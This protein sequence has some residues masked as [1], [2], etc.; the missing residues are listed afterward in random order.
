MRAGDPARS[1][2]RRRHAVRRRSTSG[3]AGRRIA[4]ARRR[5]DPAASRPRAGDGHPRSA[6]ARRLVRVVA[7][8]PVQLFVCPLRAGRAGLRP[9]TFHA[10]G[11]T[12]PCSPPPWRRERITWPSA[13]GWSAIP[14]ASP[15]S[16]RSR[17]RRSRQPLRSVIT[18]LTYR[19][20]S[21]RG[22]H[23][24]RLQSRPATPPGTPRAARRRAGRVGHPL[25]GGPASSRSTRSAARHAPGAGPR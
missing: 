7:F 5:P 10:R 12:K 23:A 15:S 9:T 11:S 14:P 25:N 8:G 20:A 22:G 3:I 19:P 4:R 18:S 13:R 6:Q 17:R 1:R 2:G 16:S 24:V 21:V